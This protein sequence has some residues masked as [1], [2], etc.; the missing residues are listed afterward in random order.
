MQITERDP[1]MSPGSKSR[2]RRKEYQSSGGFN[3][4][5]YAIRRLDRGSSSTFPASRWMALRDMGKDVL[6][7]DYTASDFRI[8]VGSNLH[9][10]TFDV[11]VVCLIQE[12]EEAADLIDLTETPD[13]SRPDRRIGGRF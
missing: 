8:A 3:S 6:A 10:D 13:V 5:T 12:E 11:I 9:I 4:P 2:N 1:P 7:G